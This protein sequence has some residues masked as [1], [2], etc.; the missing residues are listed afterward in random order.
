MYYE[1]FVRCA[2]EQGENEMVVR[3]CNAAGYVYN[4]V[5]RQSINIM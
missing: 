2:Q 5:V 4:L 1:E 3:G